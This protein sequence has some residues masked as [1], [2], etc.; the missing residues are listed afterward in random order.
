MQKVVAAVGLIILASGSAV[1]AQSLSGS[2]TA[3]VRQNSIAQQQDYSFLRTTNEVRSFVEKGY[4][5]P[6]RGNASYKVVDASFPYARPAVKLFVERI[7]TQYT[8]A[9]GEKLV[10]TSL[11]RPVSRQPR[12]AH[13]LSVHPAGM[14]VDFRISKKASCRKWFESALKGLESSSVIDATKER[15]P[16][17]YHVAVFPDAYTRYV[18]RSTG[19]TAVKVAAATSSKGMKIAQVPG[20]RS[21]ASVLP[22]T[23]EKASGDTYIV[24][25][26][27]SLWSIGKKFG[28]EPGMLKTA[29]RL[30]MSTLQPGMKLVIPTAKPSTT[31]T[32]AGE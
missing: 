22:V 3:M 1:R 25:K 17:H 26:G 9:C 19:S 20:G 2:R 15:R 32:P 23:S 21:Y 4:L 29:N 28:V 13:E 7:A 10:V 18:A 11:T 30:R 24:R 12:N 27:D 31:G 6:L 8:D 14:A 5:V 16:A